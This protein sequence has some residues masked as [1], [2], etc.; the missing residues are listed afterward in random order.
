MTQKV[1]DA[2]K[3]QTCPFTYLDGRHRRCPGLWHSPGRVK[4]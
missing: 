3:N 4:F 2:P 1:I